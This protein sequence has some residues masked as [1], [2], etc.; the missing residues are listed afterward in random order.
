MMRILSLG[1]REMAQWV[2][3]LVW[4]SGKRLGMCA[5]VSNSRAVD[6]NGRRVT[7]VDPNPARGSLTE[8]LSQ[9]RVV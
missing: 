7:G 5:R 6:V 3:M 4:H 8:S 9:G 2:K 1:P